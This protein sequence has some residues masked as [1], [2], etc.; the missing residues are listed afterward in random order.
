MENTLKAGNNLIK[1]RTSKAF[2]IKSFVVAAF[3]IIFIINE[4]T[5]NGTGGYLDEI[6][7]VCS[8]LYIVFSRKK[9]SRYDILTFLF[10]VI[11]VLIGWLSNI[12]SSLTTDLFSI[13]VDTVCVTKVISAYFA[14]KYFLTNEEKQASINMLAP[15]SKLFVIGAFICGILSLFVDL[16]MTGEKRYGIGSFKF[17]FPLNFQYIAVYILILGVIVCC[18]TI[19]QKIKRRYYFLA[20]I[21][22][23]LST[24]APALILAF[25]FVF[26]SIYFKR[27]QKLSIFAIIF[28]GIA[29]VFIA[30]YQIENYFLT[31]NVPRQLFTEYSI[32]TANTY[33]PLGSGF[34]TFGSNEASVNYS[35]LYYQYGFDS[36]WGMTPDYGPFLSDNFWQMGLAQFGWFGGLLYA[37]V[38]YRIFKSF[39]MSKYSSTKK[40][41]LYAAFIQYILHGFGSA[42]LSSSAG[43]I[44]FMAM[45]LFSAVENQDNE[46]QTKMRI[47]I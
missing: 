18:N 30:W 41:F 2:Y 11:V 44:G 43:M 36:V 45:A 13:A 8:I 15:I 27:R 28:I 17:F 9:I 39:S 47:N 7:G 35:S 4:V 16:G 33:F 22:I 38:F 1:E 12:V 37:Y 34:S 19:P 23:L 25:A 3:F 46:K 20:I 42:V 40:A 31:E 32:K 5:H 10:L 26:L 6:T 21:S 24:K 14:M 29:L